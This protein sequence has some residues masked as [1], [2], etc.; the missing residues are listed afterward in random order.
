LCLTDNQVEDRPIDRAAAAK[1]AT[2]LE[3]VAEDWPI[4]QAVAEEE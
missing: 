2:D 4:D 1:S 3:A